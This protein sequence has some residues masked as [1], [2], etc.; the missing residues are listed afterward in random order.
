MVA[1]AML[2]GVA[3]GAFLMASPVKAQ[4]QEI[5]VGV[6]ARAPFYGARAGFVFD[7]RAEFLRREEFARREAFLRHE[8]WLRAQR[9]RGYR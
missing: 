9:F 4:A 6:R 7:R 1:K 2:A 5:V 8:P 3:A